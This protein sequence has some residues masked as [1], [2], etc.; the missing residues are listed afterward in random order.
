MV[1]PQFRP[2][3]G[4]YE[5]AAERLSR[6]LAAAGHKVEV[7]TERRKLGWPRYEI[8]KD[9]VIHRIP[10]LSY[11]G[12]HTLSSVFSLFFFLLIH[13]RR[14]D[15]LHIHQ[16]GWS[17]A[18][19]SAMGLVFHK[20]VFLK[21]TNTGHFGLDAV[22]P[23][24]MIGSVLRWL[25]LNIACCIVTSARAADE[26]QAFGFPVEKICTVPNPLETEVFRPASDE[27]KS[28]LRKELGLEAKFVAVC[29]ARLSEEKNHAMLIKAWNLFADKVENAELI[30]LGQGPLDEDVRRLTAS[31]KRPNTI[32]VLGQ[33]DDPLHWYQAA[34][35]YTLSSDVE[36]LSNSLMEA[37]SSGLPVI[38][39]HVSGSED[40]FEVADIGEMVPVGDQD[41]MAEALLSL[42]KN[43]HRRQDCGQRARNYAIENYSL[44]AITKRIESC[45]RHHG[46]GG[47]PESGIPPETK[48]RH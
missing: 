12:I 21:L 44:D 23:H 18:V 1:S 35:V 43:P 31:S 3:T 5:R 37:L 19:T 22:L 4:G 41:A 42:E 7:V 11:R 33:T 36:G 46:A 30:L 47:I 10:V 28:N 17:A 29:A 48:S 40:I 32:R 9:V 13:G 45:Y 6:G 2:I 15:L 16:Y 8:S 38:S 14:F 24:G 26:A 20:P 25:H 34:D 27:K 39:T